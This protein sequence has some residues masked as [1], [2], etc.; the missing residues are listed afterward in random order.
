MNE[1]NEVSINKEDC[2]VIMPIS[3]QE[4]YPAG[5]FTYIYEQIVKPAIIEAGYT[6]FRVDE[7][8][9]STD[10]MIKIIKSIKE[11][12]MA[13]CDLSSRNP[14]V[15]YELGIRQ[16]YDK[17]VVL[18]KDN[19][20]KKIFDVGGLNTIEYNSN[21]LYENVIEAREQITK[22]IIATK[23]QNGTE[24]TLM[25]L[26][27]IQE[28]NTKEISGNDEN[29]TNQLLRVLSSQINELKKSDNDFNDSYISLSKRGLL[30]SKTEELMDRINDMKNKIDLENGDVKRI[31]SFI[32]ELEM[33]LNRLQDNVLI[34]SKDF[35]YINQRVRTIDKMIGNILYPIGT[36]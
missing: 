7:D 21:R 20:T 33:L 3:D 28:A 17:P 34:S 29:T 16:A 18:I 10:I 4:G 8:M 15:L 19:T 1:E 22:A 5:H 23:K 6:P 27:Q 25:K 24:S 31:N 12:P 9:L 13:V 14:N 30:A 26:L 2:F 35:N 11:C 32:S 36:H